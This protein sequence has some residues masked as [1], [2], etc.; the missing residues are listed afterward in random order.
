[1]VHGELHTKQ[2]KMG[3]NSH[4]TNAEKLKVL[5]FINLENTIFISSTILLISRGFSSW[6]NGFCF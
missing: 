3:Q 2:L 5:S 4:E 1:M 6:I